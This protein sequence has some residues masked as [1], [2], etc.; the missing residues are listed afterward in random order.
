MTK[1]GVNIL[2]NT[3][4]VKVENEDG[5]VKLTYIHNMGQA[6][7]KTDVFDIILIATGRTPNVDGMGLEKAN[8]K[9]DSKG[10]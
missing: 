2:L 1:D 3:Q 4:P 5:K 6:E 10:V 8:V 9:F 7:A